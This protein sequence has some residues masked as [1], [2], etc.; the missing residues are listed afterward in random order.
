MKTT[1]SHYILLLLLLVVDIVSATT[2]TIKRTPLLQLSEA[3]QNNPF[4]PRRRGDAGVAT[5]T[6]T[7][8]YPHRT[9]F[10]LPLNTRG[11]RRRTRPTELAHLGDMSWNGGNGGATFF[12]V[13]D[14]VLVCGDGRSTTTTCDTDY[15]TISS[16]ETT[17]KSP[18]PTRKTR[19]SCGD[20][21][22]TATN[23]LAH[24]GDLS[25]LRGGA[26]LDDDDNESRDSPKATR[27]RKVS[28]SSYAG[29][30]LATRELVDAC[31]F[32]LR[33]GGFFV[34]L[35]GHHT[36]VFRWTLLTV[37]VGTACIGLANSIVVLALHQFLSRSNVGGVL[38][39][40]QSLVHRS[41]MATATR[42]VYD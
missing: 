20:E 21:T 35:V 7:T 37:V 16:Q 6:T 4:V 23:T 33:G 42:P 28:S 12:V 25:W 11:R 10:S 30:N 8:F 5:A 31:L 13:P 22:F 3:R 34:S 29:A 24:L 14:E 32:A 9:S 38:V 40:E 36:H 27:R 26:M 41:Y 17:T 19:S 18:R 39:L 15:D 1:R 2:A